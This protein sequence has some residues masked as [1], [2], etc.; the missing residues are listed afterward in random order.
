M[1]DAKISYRDSYKYQL[2]EDY[3]IEVSVR[4]ADQNENTDTK[5]IA[6][7]T[8]GSLTIKQGY[9]WDGASGPARDTK[10]I[11]RGSLVH[12]AIYQL[13]RQK[14]VSAEEWRKEADKDLRKMSRADGISWF[15][16][17]LMY[18]AVRRWGALAADPASR[19][20]IETA[21]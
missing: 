8:D 5:F 18:R 10:N 1:A 9:A 21:P 19:K 6:I 15:R 16:A 12:D 3:T 4:P 7:T 14:K 2:A 17:F 13:M 20:V 11:M